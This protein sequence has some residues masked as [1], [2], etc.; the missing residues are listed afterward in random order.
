MAKYSPVL[1]PG[2]LRF[3][4]RVAGT[5]AMLV[6]ALACAALGNWQLGRAQEKRRLAADF[7]RAGPAVELSLL[8]DDV[9]RYARVIARGRYDSGHQFLLDNM[10]HAG[11]AGV[12]VLTP[13][14]L[15]DGSSVLVNRGWQAFGATRD[16]LPPVT[17]VDT[18]REVTGRLDDLPRPT[19]RLDAPPAAAWP[20]LVQY[21]RID[22]LSA[23]L[24]R[25]L[26]PRVILLDAAQPDGYVRDWTLPGTTAVRH[27]GYAVQWFAF[28][29]LAVAIWLAV[30]LRREGPAG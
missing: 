9:P 24:G 28:A 3:A 1:K 29:A 21:P 11:S 20:R 23:A 2:R 13:L 27:L 17:V 22:E 12:Q 16:V 25:R 15:S 14:V 4:P 7:A 10:S 6:A 19:I 30:S 8:G 26:R 18:P 5:I